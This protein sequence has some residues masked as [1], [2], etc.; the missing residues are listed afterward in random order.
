MLRDVP[1]QDASGIT[2]MVLDGE[3]ILLMAISDGAGSA[4][5]AEEGSAFVVREWLAQA[6]ALLSTGVDR[7]EKMLR[8]LADTVRARLFAH[9]DSLEG[10]PADYACTLLGAILFPQRALFF[11]IGDGA[12]ICRTGE[13]FQCPTW[14]YQGEFAGE[15]VFLTSASFASGYQTA[16]VES[17]DAVAGL[18]DGLERLALKMAA[19]EPSPAFF[20]PMFTGLKT[21]APGLAEEHLR[22]FLV[23]DR[24]NERTDDDKTLLLA[25]KEA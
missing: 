12:W 21:S 8:D 17:V 11:Q 13:T 20:G 22:A 14:P 19:R 24:V 3:P 15:T 5:K 16:T 7:D 4:A 1:C 6:E 23:S 2:S 25:V 9:V 18:T 10:K